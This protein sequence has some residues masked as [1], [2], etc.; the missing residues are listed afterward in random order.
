MEAIGE[1]WLFAVFIG[2]LD[3]ILITIFIRALRERRKTLINLSKEDRS[4]IQKES[5]KSAWS[6][7]KLFLKWIFYIR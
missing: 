3:I 4:T 1:S 5:G 7:L 2:V 6:N